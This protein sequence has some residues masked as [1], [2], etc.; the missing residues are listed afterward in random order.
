MESVVF[1]S[2][3]ETDDLESTPPEMGWGLIDLKFH[4]IMWLIYRTKYMNNWPKQSYVCYHDGYLVPIY[5][6]K[7]EDEN[8]GEL[9]FELHTPNYQML[10]KKLI[11]TL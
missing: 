7:S 4:S 8:A 3:F 1:Q 5:I 11:I 2:S 10:E 6:G 9:R